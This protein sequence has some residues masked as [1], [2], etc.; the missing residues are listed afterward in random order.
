MPDTTT[1]LLFAIVIVLIIIA[2]LLYGVLKQPRTFTYDIGLDPTFRDVIKELGDGARHHAEVSAVLGLLDLIEEQPELTERLRDYPAKV[3]A[4]AWT[5]YINCLGA[6]LQQAQKELSSAHQLDAGILNGGDAA[7]QR[8]I[9]REQQH[10]DSLRAKLD[11]A[12]A[13]SDQPVGP[14]AI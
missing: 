7:K 14:H 6:D 2:V 10:V 4:A 8:R 13:A 9:Q 1:V 3:Q 5:H 12:V 11:R